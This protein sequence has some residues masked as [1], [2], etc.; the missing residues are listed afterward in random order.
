MN[1]IKQQ[2]SYQPQNVLEDPPLRNSLRYP[3]QKSG[4]DTPE[5]SL[6][7]RLNLSDLPSKILAR[8]N[9]GLG[10]IAVLNT[11]SIDVPF[12]F[13]GTYPVI[14]TTNLL[15][16]FIAP[17][18]V[19][20]I[21]S[22]LDSVQSLDADDLYVRGNME[23]RGI[24]YTDSEIRTKGSIIIGEPGQGLIIKDGSTDTT[25]GTVALVAGTATV[26]NVL[27]TA[28][29]RIFL[30]IQSPGGTVGSVYVHARTLNTSFTI[31]STS[32]LDTS[33]VAYL[34]IEPI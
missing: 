20:V 30:T 21:G 33:T 18:G 9:L 8:Q 4:M 1:D 25:M 34:L 17:D 5:G 3:R 14:S 2:E 23:I 15:P 29:T 24:L 13:S 32:I 28:N 12:V 7:K 27:V 6:S 16:L 10:T 19:C 31:K 11:S 22:T 26:S